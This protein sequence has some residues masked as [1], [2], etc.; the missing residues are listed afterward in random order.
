MQLILES[1]LNLP[2]KIIWWNDSRVCIA[3]WQEYIEAP[4]VYLHAVPAAV[5]AAQELFSYI[6]SPGVESMNEKIIVNI[7]QLK[8]RLNNDV[9]DIEAAQSLGNAYYDRGDTGLAVLYYRHVLDIDPTLS[10]VRTD[11]GGMYWRNENISLAEQAFR[12]VIARDPGFGHAYVNLG[13]L[14]QL[15]R[16]NIMEARSVWQQLI[17]HSPDHEVAGKAR[18]L[19]QETAALIN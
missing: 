15:A 8:A 2:V 6:S 17:D 1:K 14:L 5:E 11:L 9:K 18:E 7:D 10:G 4:L 3:L 13:L 12:E 16:S 19:L